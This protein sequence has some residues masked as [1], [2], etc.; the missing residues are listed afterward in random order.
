MYSPQRLSSVARCAW[1]DARLNSRVYVNAFF[2]DMVVSCSE[3]R[4]FSDRLPRW[5]GKVMVRC[6]R[7]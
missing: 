4:L 2:L 1:L 5:V 7:R 6:E 3:V